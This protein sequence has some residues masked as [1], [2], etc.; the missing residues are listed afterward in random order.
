MTS[1]ELGD[2]DETN[3]DSDREDLPN[4]NPRDTTLK[5]VAWNE[6][7]PWTLL[8][9]V[10]PSSLSTSVLLLALI[11]AW[12]TPVGW[13]TAAHLFLDDVDSNSPSV[14]G[15]T[16]GQLQAWPSG[17]PPV[18]QDE[19]LSVFAGPRRALDSLA[20]AAMIPL[21]LV[22]SSSNSIEVCAYTVFGLLWSMMVWSI[23][24]SAIARITLLR[25]GR[26]SR[27]GPLEAISY[28]GRRCLSL[29]GAPLLP[30]TGVALIAAGTAI[31]GVLMRIDVLA[32]VAA[33]GWIGL[34]VMGM[35]NSLLLVGVGV[36]WPLMWCCVAAERD[37]DAF[38]AL[39]SAFAYVYQHFLRLVAYIV[40]VAAI[41]WIGSQILDFFVSLSLKTTH[42]FVGWGTGLERA[43]SSTAIDFWEQIWRSLS[44]AYP[45][46]AFWTSASIIYLLRRREI[47]QT[48]FDQVHSS[49]DDDRLTLPA[50][51]TDS[52]GVPKVETSD[53]GPDNAKTESE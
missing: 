52:Q 17:R 11:G 44:A 29:W 5:G 18:Y 41:A 13:R 20:H 33:V 34:L 24:G 19:K 15:A 27:C 3:G 4:P 7:L 31:V 50:V 48:D 46:A 23:L 21:T 53:D 6:V 8:F 37:G 42:L 26:N 38:D 12:L 51:A 28:C 32:D 39:S 22:T 49:E 35:L 45:Y 14:L 40:L 43:P 1:N 10:V 36:G 47:D 9:R 16:R 30:L 2:R 25:V